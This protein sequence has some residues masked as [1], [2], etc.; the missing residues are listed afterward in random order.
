MRSSLESG[1]PVLDLTVD[2]AVRMQ[3]R[4]SSCV[5]AGPGERH[6]HQGP[7]VRRPLKHLP[8]II[9]TRPLVTAP[10]HC[11]PRSGKLE[12]AAGEMRVLTVWEPILVPLKVVEVF[13]AKPD[14]HS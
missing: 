14:L 4:E 7:I 10:L 12:D 1:P 6:V 3:G 9:L 11:W 13:F 5:S 8:R 2:T